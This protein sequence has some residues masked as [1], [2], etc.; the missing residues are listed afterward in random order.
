MLT[1][2]N[3]PGS[4]NSMNTH[5]MF[6]KVNAQWQPLMNNFVVPY[7]MLQ[8]T[9]SQQV[10]IKYVIAPMQHHMIPPIHNYPSADYAS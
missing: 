10:P 6:Q 1:I 3:V 2:G 5:Q 8:P 9:S 4:C 7:P